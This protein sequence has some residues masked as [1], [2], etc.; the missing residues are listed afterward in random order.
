MA[1]KVITSKD[2]E[3][4]GSLNRN[5]QKIR[6]PT[7]IGSGL[8][9]SSALRDLNEKTKIFARK[10]NYQYVLTNSPLILRNGELFYAYSSTR[11]YRASQDDLETDISVRQ[12]Y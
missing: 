4:V 11:F 8:D 1:L 2:R 3:T 9:L 5:R 7:I 6:E 12:H 10:G